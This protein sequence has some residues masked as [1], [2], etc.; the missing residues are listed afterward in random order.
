MIKGTRL[1]GLN[2]IQAAVKNN[3]SVFIWVTLLY[4]RQSMKLPLFCAEIPMLASVTFTRMSNLCLGNEI[5]IK[6]NR[7]QAFFVKSNSTLLSV[8]ALN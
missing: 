2:E 7:K 3:T 8:G 4:G 1:P 5:I 6:H